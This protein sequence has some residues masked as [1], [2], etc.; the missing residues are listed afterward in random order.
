MKWSCS[1]NVP[2]LPFLCP[3][4]ANIK[5]KKAFEEKRHSERVSGWVSSCLMFPAWSI[6]GACWPGGSG[7]RPRPAGIT[8]PSFLNVFQHFS[9]IPRSVCSL[10]L[11]DGMRL[12][13]A[14]VQLARSRNLR[15]N[16]AGLGQPLEK[17][18]RR[19]RYYF[20]R[21][22]DIRACATARQDSYSQPVESFK[23]S[24][25]INRLGKSICG[26]LAINKSMQGKSCSCCLLRDPPP[27]TDMSCGK[28]GNLSGRWCHPGMHKLARTYKCSS[29]GSSEL[30]FLKVWSSQ[31]HKINAS[32]AL[33]SSF[34]HFLDRE[35]DDRKLQC[36]DWP[37]KGCRLML[38]IQT[39]PPCTVLLNDISPKGSWESP[40]Q[41]PP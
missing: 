1:Q 8:S 37:C 29:R 25:M 12:F 5:L 17:R 14:R 40:R 11:P 33:S 9:S 15:L 2:K 28:T 31:T 41:C 35:A 22:Q 20:C 7:D 34:L 36:L 6:W 27:P 23:C 38:D 39:S 32:G 21:P 24:T 10:E 4:S 30:Y 18:L 13:S 26:R 19:R 16:W 3:D